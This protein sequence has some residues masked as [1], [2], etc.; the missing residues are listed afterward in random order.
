MSLGQ[1]AAIVLSL[2]PIHLI[3]RLIRGFPVTRI[4][5]HHRLPLRLRA[6][7]LSH[8]EPAPE[9]DLV[10]HLILV[11]VGLVGWTPHHKSTRW[12]P[13]NSPVVRSEA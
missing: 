2:F 10:L 12:H 13:P 6:L 1:R 7:G 3:D 4:L 5:R 11:P 9:L 8:K